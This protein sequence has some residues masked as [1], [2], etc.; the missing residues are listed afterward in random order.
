MMKRCDWLIND[1]V[2]IAYHYMEWGVPAEKERVYRAAFE[3]FDAA[4]IALWEQEKIEN[5]LQDPGIMHNRLKVEAARINAQV[6]LQI[7]K[8]FGNFDFFIWSLVNYSPIH[9]YDDGWP[10][11]EEPSGMIH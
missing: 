8:E 5:L 6:F 10:Q 11:Y 3:G 1:K 4:R 9:N 7:A 2:Y